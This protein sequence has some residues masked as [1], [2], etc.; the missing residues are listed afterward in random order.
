MEKNFQVSGRI[1]YVS[2]P[3]LVAWHS[4]SSIS[5]FTIVAI[6]DEGYMYTTG[7]SQYGQLGNGETG[8]HFITANKIAFANCNVWTKRTTFCHAPT[9]K[10]HS[11]SDTSA[12]VIPLPEDIR[13]QQIAC[14]KHHT[15]ALEA[16][17]DGCLPRVFS[18]GCGDFGCLGHG[19]QADE[20][21]PRLIGTLA[22]L[23]L[24]LQGP[25]QMAVSAGQHC[26]LFKTANGHV[27]YWGKHRSVGEA[28]M[29]PSLVDVL[30]N[31]Q[32]VVL[33]AAAGGQT[34]FCSTANGQ[35]VTWGQGPYGELG[36]G[37][38]K[39]SSAKPAFVPSLDGCHVVSLSCGYGHTLFVVRNEDPGD[40]K[41]IQELPEVESSVF[42]NLEQNNPTPTS[43][44][45]S[46]KTGRKK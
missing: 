45:T 18:F 42:E 17:S 43:R 14:G 4:F 1:V 39:M 3:N 26:S 20:Y 28:T 44:P 7:S 5:F 11:T 37:T 8:E 27:Y 6:C 35:T 22:H 15:L 38:D 9:E 19:V 23:R 16:D 12:K 32:H 13:V 34:V 29:R 40:K 24:P 41:A 30:A 2:G 46:A 10:L 31:N 25:T 33:H 21:F 36:L